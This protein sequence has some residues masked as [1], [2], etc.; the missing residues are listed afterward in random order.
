MRPAHCY[1]V[2]RVNLDAQG[3]VVSLR[4]FNPHGFDNVPAGST[5]DAAPGDGLVTISPAQF[6]NNFVAY[7]AANA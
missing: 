2:D 5:N 4:L 1:V 3:N 6:M 7:N